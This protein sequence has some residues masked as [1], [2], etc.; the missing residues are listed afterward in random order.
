MQS[1]FLIGYE[2][3]F[4][5]E[6]F[7]E[8]GANST[9]LGSCFQY[10]RIT[11]KLTEL[12]Y[13]RN[14]GGGYLTPTFEDQTIS[15]SRFGLKL[16]FARSGALSSDFYVGLFINAPNGVNKHWNS[17]TEVRNLSLG[18]GWIVGVPF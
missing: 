18:L 1:G 10:G 11:Q 7:D 16:G 14:I 12:S 5:F 3:K 8:D 13:E 6:D 17:I 4:Y 15:M 2:S 9:Y